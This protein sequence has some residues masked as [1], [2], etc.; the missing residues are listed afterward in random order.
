MNNDINTGKSIYNHRH[1]SLRKGRWSEPGRQYL[2][3][4]VTYDRTPFF[5]DIVTGRLVVSEMHRLDTEGHVESK[6]WVIMPD[7]LH[8]LVALSGEKELSEVMM[9]LKGR[10]SQ[11]I[12]KHLK[13]KGPVWSK[14][15]HDHALRKEEDIVATA[16]YIVS[17][18]IRAGLVAHIGEYS[19]WDAVWI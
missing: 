6:A 17:N 2:V 8:W 11:R 12:N 9:L 4:T 13:R 5:L 3:S 14:A 1:H 18:P 7:H 10:S 15:F 16:R 19:L